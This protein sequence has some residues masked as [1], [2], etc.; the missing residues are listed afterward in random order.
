MYSAPIFCSYGIL[1]RITRASPPLITTG[2]AVHVAL[3]ISVPQR[4]PQSTVLAYLQGLSLVHTT[5][6]RLAH[7]SGTIYNPPIISFLQEVQPA[8]R[9]LMSPTLRLWSRLSDAQCLAL[10]RG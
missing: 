6:R 1:E 7:S 8:M 5:F 9:V 3:G 10:R 2:L 4:V